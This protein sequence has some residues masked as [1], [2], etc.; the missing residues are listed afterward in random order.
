M[1]KIMIYQMDDDEDSA[2][3]G[4]QGCVKRRRRLDSPPPLPPP[5]SLHI[6]NED[7]TKKSHLEPFSAKYED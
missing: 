7:Q 2:G 6:R 5:R 4:K 1:V 3:A